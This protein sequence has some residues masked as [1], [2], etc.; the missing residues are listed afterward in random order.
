VQNYRAVVM[1]TGA[2]LPVLGAA[3]AAPT[4]PVAVAA[5]ALHYEGSPDA[6]LI[7]A[8]PWPSPAGAALEAMYRRP[9]IGPRG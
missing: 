4:L 9:V 1:W 3:T 6:L 8:V 2:A 7:G 5:L